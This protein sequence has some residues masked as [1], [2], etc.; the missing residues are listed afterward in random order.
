MKQLMLIF[1]F[2]IIISFTVIPIALADYPSPYVTKHDMRV[3]YFPP[4]AT[5]LY[6]IYDNNGQLIR[7][8]EFDAVKIDL[9]EDLDKAYYNDKYVFQIDINTQFAEN[10]YMELIIR[11]NETLT[12]YNN[13]IQIPVDKIGTYNI[14]HIT[15]SGTIR[16][17]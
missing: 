17:Q 3:R 1:I 13:N 7:F 5:N 12:V 10:E 9:M 11:D 8:L 6:H 14:L 4:I 2:I 16:I 15:E